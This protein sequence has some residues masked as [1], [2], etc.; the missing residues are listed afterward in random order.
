MPFSATLLFDP[1]VTYSFVPS[2]LAIRFFVQ[3]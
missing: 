1:T 3:W 2:R